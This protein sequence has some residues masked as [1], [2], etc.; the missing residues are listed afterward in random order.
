[1]MIARNM[2]GASR[3]GCSCSTR[4]ALGSAQTCCARCAP[5]ARQVPTRRTSSSIPWRRA[6]LAAARTRAT[7]E[8]AQRLATGFVVLDSATIRGDTV[9]YAG[10]RADSRSEMLMLAS[11]M[12]AAMVAH[13]APRARRCAGSSWTA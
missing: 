5:S 11:A 7:S 3:R 1:M 10:R 4:L 9:A 8:V 2:K 6:E 13:A 12:R